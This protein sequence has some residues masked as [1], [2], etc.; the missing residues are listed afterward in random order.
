MMKKRAL[1]IVFLLF[2]MISMAQHISTKPEIIG[3]Q[4]NYKMI[5]DQEF[6]YPETA[7]KAEA[8]GEI[9]IGF[10]VGK[11]GI[12]KDY[13]VIQSV[14]PDLDQNYIA[15]LKYL[16]WEPGNV[17]GRIEDFKMQK[18]EKFKIKKYQKLIKKREYDLPPCKFE[19]V[20]LKYQLA[21]PKKLEQKAK[22][23]YKG[24]EVNIYQFIQ[25]YIKI[26]DAAVKQGIKGKVEISFIV[27]VSGR[28]SNFKEI[29][30][31][32]GGCT[33]EAFRLMQLLEWEPAK[34]KGEYVRT[35]YIIEVNFGS[36]SY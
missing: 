27:E 31:I 22:P 18:T 12:A 8:E 3:G 2:G 23:F 36:S 30:G 13:E 6:H 33:E 19:P 5:F 1:N 17:D 7:I 28:L 9:I 15:V 34:M 20:G 24:K 10:T 35:E 11:D 14:H 4:Y 21:P 29:K 25:Q 32:G 26:P 16:F